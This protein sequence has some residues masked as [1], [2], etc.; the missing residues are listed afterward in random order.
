[1]SYL[2]QPPSPRA[3]LN[4][5]LNGH[6][7]T[8]G[9]YALSCKKCEREH[10]AVLVLRA[11]IEAS[12]AVPA[13]P[14]QAGKTELSLRAAR[15][16]RN[17]VAGENVDELMHQWADDWDA[18]TGEPYDATPAEAGK[19]QG[20]DELLEAA[21]VVLMVN[22]NKVPGSD[23]YEAEHAAMRLLRTVVDRFPHPCAATKDPTNG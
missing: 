15:L 23:R 13:E 19:A 6:G 12:E 1:M 20:C 4:I 17:H 18:V 8:C 3:A 7:A 22:E 11:L 9:G 2:K 16:L 5:I 10:E 14:G 21:R